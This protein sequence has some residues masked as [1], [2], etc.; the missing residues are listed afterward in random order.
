VL[1][2][3]QKCNVKLGGIDISLAKYLDMS[4]FPKYPAEE[5]MIDEDIIINSTG[6]GKTS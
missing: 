6:N 1:V 4:T 3:A 2:F 5:H